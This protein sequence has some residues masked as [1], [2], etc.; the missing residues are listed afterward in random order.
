MESIN[1]VFMRIE[2]NEILKDS[3]VKIPLQ[4]IA[5]IKEVALESN[6]N[7]YIIKLNSSESFTFFNDYLNENGEVQVFY[8]LKEKQKSL[9]LASKKLQN[10]ESKIDSITMLD[11]NPL[12]HK[13]RKK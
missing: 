5:Y 12:I 9:N 7:K 13:R 3:N 4:N 10:I 6:I 2:N 8:T 11:S 1:L